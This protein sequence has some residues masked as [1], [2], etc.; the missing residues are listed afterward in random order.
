[1][2]DVRHHEAGGAAVV[3]FKTRSEAENVGHVTHTMGPGV[4]LPPLTPPVGAVF[5]AANQGAKFKGRLLHISWYNKP[6]TPS[7][8]PQQEEEE[9][10]DQDSTVRRTSRSLG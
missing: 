6:K 7:T 9:P 4:V 5:Q 8:A 3:T 10:Q 2:E 1:M